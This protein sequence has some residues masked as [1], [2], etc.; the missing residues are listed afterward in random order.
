MLFKKKGGDVPCLL[1]AVDVSKNSWE[2]KKKSDGKTQS[3]K[4]RI[5]NKPSLDTVYYSK[6]VYGGDILGFHFL[7]AWND[8]LQA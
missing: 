2:C 8:S 4:Q 7:E 3:S 6:V 5:Y 1:V